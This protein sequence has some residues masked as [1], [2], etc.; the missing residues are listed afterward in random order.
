MERRT[1]L[2]GG[3]MTLKEEYQ[4]DVVFTKACEEAGIKP[5]LRQYSKWKNGKGIAFKMK[6]K[7][8]PK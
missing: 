7:L 1:F 8:L 6:H 5:T 3:E 4:K 2:Q